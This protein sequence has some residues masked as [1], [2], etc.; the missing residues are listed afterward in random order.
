MR[1]KWSVQLEE[2]FGV[3]LPND[4]RAWFDDEIWQNGGSTEY[5]EPE[6]PQDLL[7][8]Q[9]ATICGGL[10][11][12]DTFPI[13]GNG[14]GDC[15]CLR[16]GWD[17][18]V[19]EVIRW[20]HETGSWTPYGETLSEAIGLDAVRWPADFPYDADDESRDLHPHLDWAIACLEQESNAP[21]GL[22]DMLAPD[23]PPQFEQ[24][25]QSG[26]AVDSVRGLLCEELLATDLAYYCRQHGERRLAETLQIDWQ[27][28]A[29]WRFDAARIPE[30]MMGKLCE[31]TGIPAERILAQDWDQAAALANEVLQ[32]RTDLAWPFAVAGWAAER[33]GN[34]ERAIELYFAGLE[35]L[36]SSEDFTETWK[37]GPSPVGV[38]FVVGR[39]IELGPS[40]PANIRQNGYLSVVSPHPYKR[41]IQSGAL[42]EYWLK[43]GDEAERLE[44]H[45]EAYRCF[46]AAGWDIFYANDM[47]LIL[48]RLAQAAHAGGS[49][50]LAKLAERHR[51]RVI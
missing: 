47:P 37:L 51:Q 29:V 26:F 34:V 5:G 25:I 42:R 2:H 15:L 8:P 4:V 10:M 7:R 18:Q 38:K 19:T 11:L 40:L 45:A 14:C 22:R 35:S 27:E 49:V 31:T 17:G 21:A 39:L 33:A 1:T 44:N 24:L 28:I 20:L 9:S 16:F 36:G 46:F 32:S 13:L 41:G 12:P 6:R 48:D 30:K 3:T 50:A 23:A 43:R